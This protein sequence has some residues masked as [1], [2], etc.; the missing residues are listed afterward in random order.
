MADDQLTAAQE[1]NTIL[2]RIQKIGEDAHK[3]DE[4][5][6]EDR[7]AEAATTEEQLKLDQKIADLAVKADTRRKRNCHVGC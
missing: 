5:A 7:A 6:A 1:G 3:H 4:K 2:K